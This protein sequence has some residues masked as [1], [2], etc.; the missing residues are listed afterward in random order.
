MTAPSH[1]AIGAYVA[2]AG[3]TFSVAV[4]AGVV[5]GSVVVVYA[6]VDGTATTVTAMPPGF[7]HAEGSPVDAENHH[8]QVM[9]KRATGADAGTYDF[10]LSGFAYHEAVCVRY[11]NVV[12]TGSP[13]DTPTA[14]A[15]DDTIGSGSPPVETTTL[16]PDRLLLHA[17]TNW[18]GGTWT[19]PAGFV[20]RVQGG[21]GV[22]T[23][24]DKTQA[25]PGLSGT[26]TATSTNSNKRTAWLGALIGTT[27]GPPPPT[28]TMSP[29]TRSTSSATPAV[30]GTATISPA[31][32]TAPTMTGG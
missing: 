16:G 17:A 9:W 19:P 25:V 11:D 31:V 6:F 4:P 7:A 18:A 23:A 10:A 13:F 21:V 32:R 8:L 2:T 3:T 29:A 28:G 15:V 27:T 12:A 5:N 20:K 1:A 14:V 30:R 24:A 26:V 22:V